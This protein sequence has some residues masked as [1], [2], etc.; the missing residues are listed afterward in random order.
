M[1][2]VRRIAALAFAAALMS[3]LYRDFERIQDFSIWALAIH[4][5]YFQLPLKSR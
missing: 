2:A 5:L 4:F 1:K 3:E